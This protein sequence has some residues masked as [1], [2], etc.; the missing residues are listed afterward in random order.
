MGIRRMVLSGVGASVFFTGSLGYAAEPAV[1]PR[2]TEALQKMVN[3]FQGAESLSFKAIAVTEDVSSTLQK[4]QLDTSMEGVIQRP[5]KVYFKKSGN[6]QASLWYDGQTAT[7]LD[8]K[9]NK[10]AKVAVN[11]DLHALVAKLDEL[12]I[13]TPFA[14][15][16]DKGILQHVEKHVFKGDYYGATEVDG[17]PTIHL[18]FRQDSVDWQLWTDAATGAPK[19]VV[20]TSK[21]LAAAPEH[22]LLFKEAI[23]NSAAIQ[24]AAF[25]A[26]I[27]AD[28]TEVR[29]QSDESAALRHSAW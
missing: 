24:E 2:V 17:T 27:P 3:Y 22:M 20:I 19:K 15:L 16:L 11:G 12:G 4:L 13:E 25:E 21:M 23:V 26:Q 1:E 8:R 28:A 6:E 10:Y 5:N 9:T 14:G 29:M 18:A 7:I